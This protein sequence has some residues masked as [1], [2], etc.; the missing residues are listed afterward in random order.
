MTKDVNTGR[1]YVDPDSCSRIEVRLVAREAAL[2]EASFSGVGFWTSRGSTFARKSD[3]QEVGRVR[4]ANGESGV[5]LR[6][7][8]AS[9]CVSSQH[10]SPTS[11]TYQT[12]AFKPYA[13]Y[14]VQSAGETH[15][16]R[17]W[18]KMQG[19]H[20]LGRTAPGVSP[21]VDSTGFD[22]QADLLER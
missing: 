11:N 20:L 4:L 22:R 9:V 19:N 6:F 16:Y 14:D 15:R 17:V 21:M 3:L 8:G 1:V 18:E 2:N 10:G 5:V 13:A 7:A 12:F